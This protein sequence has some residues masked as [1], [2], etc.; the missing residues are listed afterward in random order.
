MQQTENIAA[1]HIMSERLGLGGEERVE[2]LKIDFGTLELRPGI[3]VDV[4]RVDAADQIF[5]QTAL[6]FIP[7]ESLERRGRDDA[8]KIPDHRFDHAIA[9]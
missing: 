4:G 3:F 1:R 6:G 7:V 5:G 2:T 9:P 8:A